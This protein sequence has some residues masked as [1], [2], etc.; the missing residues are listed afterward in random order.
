MSTHQHPSYDVEPGLTPA[1]MDTRAA[2]EHMHAV[3]REV[4]AGETP[5]TVLHDAIRALGHSYDDQGAAQS[6]AA[7]FLARLRR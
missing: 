1:L 2:R 4:V 7:Q 6:E 5:L 3:A